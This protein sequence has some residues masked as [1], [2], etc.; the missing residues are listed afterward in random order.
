MPRKQNGF[1][2][3]SS[4]AFKGSGRVDKGKAVG[5]FGQYPSDRQYGTSVY[6]TVIENWNLNSGWTKWR[7]GYELYNQ[8]AY[9]RTNVFNP[10][11]DPGKPTS[12]DNPVYV[13]A[14]LRSLL[15][16]GTPYEI[17]TLFTSIEMPTNKSDVNTHYVVKRFV[18][19]DS[20]LAQ[21][22][23]R[24]PEKLEKQQRD[25]NEVWFKGVSNET[26]ARLLLQMLNERLTDGETEASLKNV[27]TNSPRVNADI[28][29]VYKGKT[30]SQFGLEQ[31]GLSD[32]VVKVKIPI[33]GITIEENKSEIK[34]VNQGLSTYTI[35]ASGI[36]SLTDINQLIGKIVYIQ[37][38]YEDKDINTLDKVEWID[39]NNYFA[40]SVEETEKN[41]EVVI[42]DPGVSVLPPSMYDIATLPKILSAVDCDYTI[43][44]GY[45]FLK[46]EYQRF[47][48]RKYLTA[49]LVKDE[50]E[51]V[52]YSV[53]PFTIL[54]ASVIG[55]YLELVSVP[56]TSEIKLY[57]E[58][59][60]ATLVFAENSFVRYVEPSSAAFTKA[61]DTNV[62]PWQDEVFTS[63]ETL[64]PAEVYT[65]D[66]PSYSKTIIAMPQ[67]TQHNE[68]RK[69]NRQNRYPL[70]SAMGTNRFENLGIDKVAGKAASWATAKD[71][72]SFKFCKHTV[73][74]MFVDG[75]QLIEPS[76]YPTQIERDLFE[77]KLEKE[78]A[79]LSEA[80]R[81]SAERSGISLTE[82]VFSLA[83]GLNLDDIETGYVVLNSN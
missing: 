64:K 63:G 22:T 80:W 73:T 79:E 81:L 37:D 54:G 14:V 9:A 3:T 29:A 76:Q 2:S 6:R 59:N 60:D 69:V 74:G 56:F 75:V 4:F 70:P 18:S 45:A 58:I 33:D 20:G 13:P 61:I 23:G 24:T 15:Y 32:T 5:A 38:F 57:A 44:G 47:F 36:E 78:L 66:C 39:Y 30:P 12:D 40:V 52:S 26:R 16:Q 28:P 49:D 31:T 27:L 8:A 71:K 1:G 65:C 48:G 17:E 11:Y 83:Q 19:D 55:N 82:I 7:R 53:F 72:H 46:E 50:I 77:E 21:I 34:V 41:K 51:V 67:A 35:P 42:L 10:D 62:D 25:F 68:E 43:T